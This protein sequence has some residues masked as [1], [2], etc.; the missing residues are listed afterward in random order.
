MEPLAPTL[1]DQIWD[2]LKIVMIVVAALAPF[3]IAFLVI[4]FNQ[5]KKRLVRQYETHRGLVEKRLEAYGRMGPKLNDIISFLSYTGNWKELTPMD[6]LQIKRELDKDM[7]TSAPLF[8][9][10][11]AGSYHSLMQLCFIS[12]S[13][14]EHDEKIKSHYELR[15]QQDPDWS[16]AWI[17]WFDPKNVADA[18]RVREH[19]EELTGFFKK[20]LNS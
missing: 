1:S 13:G 18:I 20:E 10:E 2:S 12:I 19:Y 7:A 8:S 15:Q 6:M 16:D 5:T 11:L 4:R 17:P 14:W 3:V 9:E